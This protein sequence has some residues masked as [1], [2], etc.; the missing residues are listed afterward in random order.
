MSNLR[1]ALRTI[2]PPQ[3]KGA[4]H[5]AAGRNRDAFH[6]VAEQQRR[7]VPTREPRVQRRSIENP[8]LERDAKHR[9]TRPSETI[10]HGPVLDDR[11]GRIAEA[12]L[13]MP[14]AHLQRRGER[15]QRHEPD[16]K[17]P[18][19]R[20]IRALGRHPGRCQREHVAQG[21]RAPI[22]R[23]EQR[24][25]LKDDP[26]TARTGVVRILHDLREPLQAVP[27]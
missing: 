25:C 2:I 21:D 10:G 4:V 23:H 17:A 13:V 3:P 26:H 22:V 20:R 24:I 9:V 7:L 1:G 8:W 12:D 5:I 16:T 19:R 11:D 14:R 27:G 15:L 6:V 18:S